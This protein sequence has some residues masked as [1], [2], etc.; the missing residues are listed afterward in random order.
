MWI[1][2]IEDSDGLGIFYSEKHKRITNTTKCCNK[3]ET[4]HYD[5]PDYIHN[6][7]DFCA[8]KRVTQIYRHIEYSELLKLI[9]E[10]FRI[11]K[12][13][14]YFGKSGKSQICYKKSDILEQIDITNQIIT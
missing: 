9:K 6:L 1:Y 13:R 12:I 5:I 4:P 11:Y 14:T 10:G 7:D 8:F 3:L 2:R